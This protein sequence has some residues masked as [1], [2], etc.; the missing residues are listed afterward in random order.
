MKMLAALLLLALT[1][2]SYA[3]TYNVAAV[4]SGTTTLLT[5]DTINFSLV[6]GTAFITNRSATD[7]WVTLDGSTPTI[8]G[9]EVYVVP[10]GS[11]R[12]ILIPDPLNARQVKI[13]ASV[14]SAYT[15]DVY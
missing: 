9:D 10:A 8:G 7:I 1:A 4:K 5:V 15:V 12:H 3:A 13:T 6:C 11:T 2:P 14:A